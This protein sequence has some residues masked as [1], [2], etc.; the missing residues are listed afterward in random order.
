MKKIVED[1]TLNTIEKVKKRRKRNERT[2]GT[3]N[4]KRKHITMMNIQLET[5]PSPGELRT[6]EVG[7]RAVTTTGNREGTVVTRAA[8]SVALGKTNKREAA[9]GRVMLLTTTTAGISNAGRMHR[10][11][12]PGGTGTAQRISDWSR[13][14]EARK[15]GNGPGSAPD[16]PL[17]TNDVY[18]LSC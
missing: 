18:K 15:S 6:R 3:M 12:S 7:M 10:M 5:R 9:G 17:T 8:A 13:R 1:G 14:N 11:R 16:P 4:T 2:P